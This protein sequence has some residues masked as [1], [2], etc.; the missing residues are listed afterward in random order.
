MEPERYPVRLARLGLEMECVNE[1]VRIR[2]Y[3]IFRDSLGNYLNVVVDTNHVMFTSQI[4]MDLVTVNLVHSNGA[5]LCFIIQL[6]FLDKSSDNVV[7]I[8][9]LGNE[10]VVCLLIGR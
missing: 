7:Y 1:V 5:S 2:I 9:V 4:L 8:A 3:I 10:N 6:S